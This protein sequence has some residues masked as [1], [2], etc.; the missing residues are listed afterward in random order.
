MA[1]SK[2]KKKNNEE[3]KGL[4]TMISVLLCLIALVIGFAGGFFYKMMDPSEEVVPVSAEADIPAEVPASE[5]LF[6]DSTVIDSYY[7]VINRSHPISENYVAGSGE[8]VSVENEKQLEKKAAEALAPMLEALRAEGMD[9]IVQSG[10]RTDSDQ[11]YLYDRQIER[12]NGD[13]LKAATISAVPL[14]SEHQAGLAVDL[15]VDGSLTEEFGSTPQGKW[16]YAHCAEYGFIL[17]YPAGKEEITGIISE[18]WHFRF[19]GSPEQAKAIMESGLCMEEYF[20]KELRAE[21]ID[22]YLPYLK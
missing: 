22:P 10:Y 8:L 9:I 21:D 13:E 17:R 18:P 3:N 5:Q 20:G 1:K 15:S 16:L 11:E 7:Q 4:L 14:T 12:Q 2:K 19:V 6:I